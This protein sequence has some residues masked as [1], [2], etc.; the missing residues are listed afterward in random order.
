MKGKRFIPKQIIRIIKESKKRHQKYRYLPKYGISEQTFYNWKS[1]YG[2]MEV[3]D[4]RYA[5]EGFGRR[6]PTAERSGCR[7]KLEQ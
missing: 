7:F 1:E 3:S 6:E 4:G 2:G 5:P